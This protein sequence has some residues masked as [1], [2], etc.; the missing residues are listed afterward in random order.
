MKLTE[1]L[2]GFIKKERSEINNDNQNFNETLNLII[3]DT[4]KKKKC[5]HTN[6]YYLLQLLWVSNRNSLYK[7]KL[8]KY[9]FSR[10]MRES[11]RIFLKSSLLA[12][13][14]C[15][16]C[17]KKSANINIKESQTIH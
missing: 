1:Y 2:K 15:P 4:F 9:I 13:K 3:D 12:K 10:L 5:L 8:A 6:Y 7:T 16:C 11:E 14:L 17:N